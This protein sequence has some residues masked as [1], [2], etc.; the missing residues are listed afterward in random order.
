MQMKKYDR[1][2]IHYSPVNQWIFIENKS[3]QVNV[4][5][6]SIMNEWGDDRKQRWSAWI[7]F[8]NFSLKILRVKKKKNGKKPAK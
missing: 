5:I 7:F 1:L 4:R 6:I 8:S 2:Q 3:L